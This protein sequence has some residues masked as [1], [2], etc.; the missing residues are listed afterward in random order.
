MTSSWTLTLWIG[1]SVDLSRDDVCIQYRTNNQHREHFIQHH[2]NRTGEANSSTLNRFLKSEFRYLDYASSRIAIQNHDNLKI[3]RNHPKYWKMLKILKN[4]SQNI[5][6]RKIFL[7]MSKIEKFKILKVR[8]S[9][10]SGLS[11]TS[12]SSPG[13]GCD[14]GHPQWLPQRVKVWRKLTSPLTG[15]ALS[16]PGPV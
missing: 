9:G 10:E 3:S 8:N 4:I 1:H 12:T 7:K 5:E 13:A 15:I 16:S 2:R 6:V 14:A 11:A